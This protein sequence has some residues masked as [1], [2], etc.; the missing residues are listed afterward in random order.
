VNQITQDQTKQESNVHF[1]QK[2]ALEL[3]L[4]SQL[5]SLNS[6]HKSLTTKSVTNYKIQFQQA[7]K[8][9]FQHDN[10]CNFNRKRDNEIQFQHDNKIQ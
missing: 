1:H 7:N 8:L 6:N 2:L 10:E 9:Q 3:Q 5:S 4:Q